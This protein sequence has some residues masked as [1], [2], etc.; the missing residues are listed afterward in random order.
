MGLLRTQVLFSPAFFLFVFNLFTYAHSRTCVRVYVRVCLHSEVV[1][2]V[3]QEPL[4]WRRTT[5][6]V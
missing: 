2:R 5:H 6:A 3:L 4:V 1:A